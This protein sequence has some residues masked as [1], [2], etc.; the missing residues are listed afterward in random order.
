MADYRPEGYNPI[1]GY[2]ADELR[3]AARTGAIVEGRVTLCDTEHDLIVN[4]GAMTGR[5]PHDEAAQGIRTGRTK[6]I[7][8]LSRVGKPVCCKV[9][10]IEEGKDGRPTALLSRRL[11]QEE[12]LFAMLQTLSP[13]DVLPARVTHMEDFGAFV[14]IG[15]G[16]ISLIGIENISVSRISHPSDRFTVGQNIFVCVS[17]VDRELNRI[18]LS[19][20]E[21]LGTWAE[22]A[23]SFE[24]GQTVPGIVRGVES[25]GTFIELRPNL[26]GL[27]ER[28]AQISPGQR[29]SVYIKAILPE[30]MKI[31]LVL[32]DVWEEPPTPITPA[33]YYITS[34][35]VDSWRYQPG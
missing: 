4:L 8:I 9:M 20:K 24:A 25:Y 15:C 22:N 31:K 11:V 32:V 17:G 6:E 27:S 34:G 23:A 30:R 33:D 29:V 16:I 19:H 12:A 5:I 10:R 26:S 35:R 21:L 28:Q 1:T 18:Y 2:T 7:A 3:A 13:G 14:D